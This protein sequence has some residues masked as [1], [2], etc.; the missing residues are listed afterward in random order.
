MGCQNSLACLVRVTY[1]VT[2]L[3]LPNI[4]TRWAKLSPYNQSK[5][6]RLY[7]LVVTHTVT[8][9]SVNSSN[10][11]VKLSPSSLLVLTASQ[12][13]WVYRVFRSSNL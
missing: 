1:I 11:W 9:L 3:Y 8:S 7:R 4:R 2:S 12:A 10:R 13:S 5:S 6:S